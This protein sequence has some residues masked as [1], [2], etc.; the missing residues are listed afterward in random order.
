M[1]FWP[2]SFCLLSFLGYPLEVLSDCSNQS[3]RTIMITYPC[4][5]DPRTRHFYKVK[6]GFTGVFIF[7]YFVLKHRLW[8]LVRSVANV[9][10]TCTKNLCFEQIFLKKS[11]KIFQLKITIFTAIEILSILHRRLI[12][13]RYL[14]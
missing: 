8:V 5:V 13:M 2:T 11:I 14:L 7:P 1:F 4:S 9:V 10:L 12:I 6:I 3:L